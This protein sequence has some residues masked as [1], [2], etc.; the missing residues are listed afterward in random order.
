MRFP[1]AVM[2]DRHQR[3]EFAAQFTQLPVLS[4]TTQCWPA[5]QTK[6]SQRSGPPSCPP[7]PEVLPPLP[8][9]TKSPE[10]LLVV[11]PAPP[12]PPTPV[13]VGR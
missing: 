8:T 11:D 5:S 9:V 1:G 12:A 10:L 6:P 13:D 2:R 7:A 4:V 3:V